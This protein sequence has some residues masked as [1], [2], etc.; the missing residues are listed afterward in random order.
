V[1]AAR[2][3]GGLIGFAYGHRWLWKLQRDP[4]ECQLFDR[5]GHRAAELEDSFAVYLLAVAPSRQRTGLG[6]RLLRSLVQLAGCQR[7]WLLTR[8]DATPAMALYVSGGWA[9]IG[10]GPDTSDG[11]PGVVLAWQVDQSRGKAEPG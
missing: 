4:W 3:R 11:R 10:H 8:D 2:E 5:L 1:A 9:P 7:A 6:R